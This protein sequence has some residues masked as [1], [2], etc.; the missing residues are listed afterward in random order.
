VDNLTRVEA[1]TSQATY[2]ILSEAEQGHARRSAAVGSRSLAA[3]EAAYP[4]YP[5]FTIFVK[6]GVHKCLGMVEI[7]LDLHF[8]PVT[9]F[10]PWLI[11]LQTSEA[12]KHAESCGSG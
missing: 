1:Q 2:F 4:A 8:P 10:A 12:G 7:I 6:S 11:L 5:Y 9:H 3:D